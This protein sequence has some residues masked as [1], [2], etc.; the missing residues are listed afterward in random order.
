MAYHLC[1][2]GPWLGWH[3]DS[4]TPVRQVVAPTGGSIRGYFPSIKTGRMIG[5][6]QLLELDA[7]YLLE[8]SPQVLDIKE[9]PFK[10]HYGLSGRMRRYTPDFAL[11]LSDG[12]ALVIEVKPSRSLAK[13]EVQAKMEAIE[14]A[15]GRQGYNFLVRSEVEIRREP[16]LGNLK[17]LFKYRRNAV[18]ADLL[19]GLQRLVKLH[20]SNPVMMLGEFADLLG[21]MKLAMALLANGQVSYDSDA[22]LGS[23]LAVTINRREVSHGLENW[24]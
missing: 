2:T 3:R 17:Q 14:E 7:L 5:Y 15:M 13:H 23:K 18:T 20:K 1:A 24:L 6:E 21:S 16:R 8:F 22:P 12:S 4:H 9:Q 10:F 19:I 11:T